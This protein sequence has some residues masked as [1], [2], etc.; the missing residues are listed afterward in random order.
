MSYGPHGFDFAARRNGKLLLVDAKQTTPQTARRI[1]QLGDQL[2]PAAARYAQLHQEAVPEFALACAGVLSKPIRDR[3]AGRGCTCGTDP[4]I[5]AKKGLAGRIPGAVRI[6]QPCA[7]DPRWARRVANAV[8]ILR[9]LMLQ[10]RRV[11]GESL[12]RS[13]S[14]LA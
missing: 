2:K 4:W 3:A 12:E 13:G 14:F 7:G 6:R 8:L 5:Q 1:K 11:T 9:V 10:C